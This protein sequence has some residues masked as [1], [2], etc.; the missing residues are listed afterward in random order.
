M[1]RLLTEDKKK[2]RVLDSEPV[3][4]ILRDYPTELFRRYVTVDGTW[5]RYYSAEAKRQPQQL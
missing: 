1:Q 3:L 4:A 5:I 2:I